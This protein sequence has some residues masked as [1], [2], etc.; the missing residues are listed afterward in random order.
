MKDDDFISLDSEG[1]KNWIIEQ[2]EKMKISDIVKLHH[3]L[4]NEFGFKI[5]SEN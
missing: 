1:L 3:F 4:R 5:E 2:I